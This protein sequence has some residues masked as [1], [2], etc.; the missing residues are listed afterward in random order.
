MPKGGRGMGSERASGEQQLF[1]PISL[2]LINSVFGCT[3]RSAA[4]QEIKHR[5]YLKAEFPSSR[6][7]RRL[8][9]IVCNQCA[10]SGS[11]VSE[12]HYWRNPFGLA[13]LFMWRGTELE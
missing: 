11:G 7:P 5:Q 13:V 9:S 3:L 6:L 1:S 2:K 4:R 8:Q 10:A 12:V